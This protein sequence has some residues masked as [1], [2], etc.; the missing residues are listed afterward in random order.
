MNSHGRSELQE[1]C[2]QLFAIGSE[3]RFGMKLNALHFQFTMPQSHDDVAGVSRN[4]ETRRHR[5]SFNDQRVIATGAKLVAQSGKDRLAVVMNIRRFTVH[6]LRRAHDFPA[7]RLTNRLVAQTHTEQRYLSSESLDHIER[8][9]RIIRSSWS[10]RDHDPLRAQSI[11][12]LVEC[13][14]IVATHF[15]RRAQLTEILDEVVS[16]RVVVIDD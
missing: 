1:V 10:G 3:N 5:L 16:E 7:K 2:E 9:S 13:D 4:F 6:Q 15:N 8:D 14:L 11:L 12:N